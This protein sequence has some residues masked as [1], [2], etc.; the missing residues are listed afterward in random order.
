MDSDSTVDDAPIGSDPLIMPGEDDPMDLNE[1]LETFSR[2]DEH[3]TVEFQIETGYEGPTGGIST[4]RDTTFRAYEYRSGYIF[5]LCIPHRNIV[6]TAIR[7]EMDL[8]PMLMKMLQY[9]NEN[10]DG[11]MYVHEF[12][13]RDG[14]ESI[15]QAVEQ[16]IDL[17]TNNEQSG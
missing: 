17:L 6:D 7:T 10:Y 1:F 16:F 11:I 14:Y 13:G 4:E 2:D 8:T 5:I 15:Q 12:G 3:L 9:I